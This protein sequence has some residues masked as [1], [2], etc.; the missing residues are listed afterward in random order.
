MNQD[1]TSIAKTIEQG[2]GIIGIELGSTRIKTV[3]I[4]PDHK[5]LASGGHGWENSYVDGVWTYSL[6]EIWEGLQQSYQSLAKA[7][8]DQYGVVL[9]QVSSIGISGMMHG[10][11]VFDRDQALLTPFRTWRNNITGEASRQLTDLFAYPVP[12]RWSIAHLQQAILNE[13]PHLPKIDYLTTL[14]GYIHWQLTG[15]KVVGIGEASGMFPIDS[16]AK[17]FNQTMI[18]KF[19]RH[20]AGKGFPWTL[21]GIL[22]QVLTAGQTAGKLTET[23]ARRLDPSGELLPGIP[24]CPPEGDAGTGMAATNAVAR[25]TGNVSAGT[26]VFAMIVLEK[27]LQKVYAEIDLV[28]T[29]SGDP[30]ALV[31]SNNCS[32]DLDAWIAL[33]GQAAKAWGLELKT[34][35]LYSSLL[36]MALQAEPDAGG[37]LSYGYVSGEHITGFEQGRPLFARSE[38]SQFNLQNFMRVHLMTA[39]G[40]LKTGLDILLKQEGVRV[41][42]ILGHGGFFKDREVGQT[43]MGAAVNTP[44][45][46]MDTAGEGGAWGIALLA[47][48]MVGKAPEE[49][50]ED[51]LGQR[52][53]AGMSGTT[54]EPKPEDVDGFNRFMARYAQGLPIESAAVE[55][56]D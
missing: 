28:A 56:L 11:L 21:G 8:L 15:E 14:A 12:Q 13:E 35:E 47:A 46:V 31:H 5:P 3:L 33:F 50:L 55:N 40:A 17:T 20:N 45:T 30:V 2:L 10:Y 42:S 26:S 22:P 9:R 24:M 29:P 6:E 41:D 1:T 32:S 36:N 44:V 52:V 4:G 7:V 43:I 19:D 48:Y 18:E 38:N 51:Y 49:T 37:L 34:S 53:F 39:L 23:G 54:L 16:A 27:P 25:R